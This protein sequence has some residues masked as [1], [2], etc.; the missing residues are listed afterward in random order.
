MT[1]PT[2]ADLR[3]IAEQFERAQYPKL[4]G[5]LREV[6]GWKERKRKTKTKE[7]K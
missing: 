4:A 1:N 6:A 2:P 7:K 3:R 5:V